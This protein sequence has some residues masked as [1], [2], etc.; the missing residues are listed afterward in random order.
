MNE[1]EQ[2]RLKVL[3][4]TISG[5]MSRKQAAE[6]M[7]ISVRHTK[8]L[9][10]GYRR[11]GA[12]ALAHGNRGR[13]PA[14]ALR[15]DVRE[16]VTELARSK[17]T[18]F[19]FSH[20]TEL[21]EERE[22]TR[23]SRST[24]RRILLK[25]GLRSPRRRKAP[26][27][28]SRRARF[29]QEGMLLQIDGS[30]HDW[31]EGRGSPFCLIGAIDDATGKVPYAHF[32]ERED[33]RGYFK[34]LR[35]ITARYGIPL[36]LYHDRHSIFEVTP[37][38]LPTLEEQLEGKNPKT[39]FE[40][41]MKELGITSISA[42]SPQA[43]GRIERLWNTFQDRLTSELRLAQAKTLDEA[44]LVLAGF[45]ARFNR[46]FAVK[47]TEPGLAY[48]KVRDGFK[49]EEYF[50]YKHPRTV[51]TD[52]VVCFGPH[53]LQILPSPD[54]ASYA[55]CKVQVYEGLDGDLTVYHEGKLLAS[56][57]ASLE[58][59][60]LRQTVTTTSLTGRVY[61]KPDPDHPWRGKYRKFFD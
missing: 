49:A 45:L 36:A 30:P 35:E 50:C 15:E 19:N 41:L 20:F 27:H 25:G 11:E 6:V 7:G 33:S 23:L 24:V 17:Y 32:Q 56:R 53:R 26:K 55:R 58:S 38:N 1:K 3:N 4:L 5:K 21:L 12:A 46:K 52:N 14:H 16:K 13:K 60:K 22:D 57:K 44:N 59:I 28:R 61:T 2:K 48:R 40:R 39:Q 51:G 8:R 9:V 34:M 31:L 42:N 43:K 37:N 18:G 54:R 10:A 29:A 47:A